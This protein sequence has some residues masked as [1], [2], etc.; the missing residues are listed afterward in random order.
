VPAQP[1]YTCPY[2]ARVCLLPARIALADIRPVEKHD[3][4][5][6]LSKPTPSD[7]LL[8]FG[9]P[10]LLIKQKHFSNFSFS[11]VYKNPTFAS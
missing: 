10:F 5:K 3:E 11:Y 9:F 7:K 2:I 8:I 1:T 4:I 6:K